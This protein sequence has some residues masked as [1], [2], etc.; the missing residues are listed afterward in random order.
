MPSISQIMQCGF[1]FESATKFLAEPY[2]HRATLQ[3]ITETFQQIPLI[4]ALIA[5]GFT[6]QQAIDKILYN[7]NGNEETPRQTRQKYMNNERV[8][9]HREKLRRLRELE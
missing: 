9:R 3:A 6:E 5:Q 7:T 8:K 2:E 1:T 4:Q